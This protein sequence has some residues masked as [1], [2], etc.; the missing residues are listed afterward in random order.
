MG[1]PKPKPGRSEV[2]EPID[3][4]YENRVV[5]ASAINLGRVMVNQGVSGTSA[6][7]TTGDDNNFA[8]V[9]VNGIS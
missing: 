1:G 4:K 3:E 6:L 8:R 7:T 2:A 5:N 9:K